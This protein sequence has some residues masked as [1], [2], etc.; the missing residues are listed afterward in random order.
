MLCK[1]GS[2]GRNSLARLK[3]YRVVFLSSAFSAIG[4]HDFGDRQMGHDINCDLFGDLLSLLPLPS[5]FLM[6]VLLSICNLGL[7]RGEFQLNVRHLRVCE[8]PWRNVRAVSSPEPLRGIRAVGR[9]WVHFSTQS[10]CGG[11]CPRGTGT[12][13]GTGVS[14]T[15]VR[16]GICARIES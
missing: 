16:W 10:L 4:E 6:Y 15:G 8:S 7:N 2:R 9:V 12:S 13:V 1:G 3:F 11:S 5:E 14:W